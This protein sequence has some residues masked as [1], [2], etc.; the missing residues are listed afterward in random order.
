MRKNLFRLFALILTLALA[1]GILSSCS[2][3]NYYYEEYYDQNF[4]TLSFEVRRDHWVWNDEDGRY[5]YFFNDVPQI[6]SNAMDK[7]AVVGK[8]I[9]REG[10]YDVAKPL[11]FVHSY[12]DEFGIEYTETISFDYSV[13]SVGFYIQ[14]SDLQTTYLDTYNFRINIFYKLN[15]L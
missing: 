9:I 8:V 10:N 6:N 11:P 13:G 7:G 5:E 15:N 2:D 14:T 3:D 1:G 4:E 12:I